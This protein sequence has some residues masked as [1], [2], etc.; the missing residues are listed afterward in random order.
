[1]RE[2]KYFGRKSAPLRKQSLILFTYNKIRN[3]RLTHLNVKIFFIAS[4][5]AKLIDY[6]VSGMD[7]ESYTHHRVNITTYLEI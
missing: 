7:I 4:W 3:S 2:L 5:I 6:L 1:M